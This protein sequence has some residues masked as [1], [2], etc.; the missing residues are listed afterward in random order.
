MTH[1]SPLKPREPRNSE[2]NVVLVE[3]A[4]FLA[5]DRWM[6]KQLSKLVDRWA[7]MAAPRSQ[8]FESVSARFQR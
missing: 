7:H 8:Q 5:F 6:D 2:P 1:N 4:P 3:S